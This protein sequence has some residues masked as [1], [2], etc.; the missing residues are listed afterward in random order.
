MRKGKHQFDP[1]D[2][3]TQETVFFET[4]DSESAF[5]AQKPPKR[6]ELTE[7]GMRHNC[8]VRKLFNNI[9]PGLPIDHDPPETR[10]DPETLAGAVEK[11]L[12]RLKINETPWLNSLSQAWPDLVPPEV[13]KVA[14]PGKWENNTLYI[15]VDSSPHLFEIRRTHLRDIEKT[16][17]TFAGGNRVRQVRLLVNSI[18]LP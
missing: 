1:A 13:A 7:R 10:Q 15:Y 11:I 9:I 2:D 16:V 5:L 3:L 6:R 12:S 4:N 18:A 17:K 14:R 8:G